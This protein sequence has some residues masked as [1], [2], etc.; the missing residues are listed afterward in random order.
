MITYVNGVSTSASETNTPN[1]SA[2]GLD[3][4]A[5]TYNNNNNWFRGSIDEARISAI[6]RSADW[7]KTEYTN[8]NSPSTFTAVG[9][10]VIAHTHAKGLFE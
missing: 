6:A 5:S 4:G 8:Q 3:L 2:G 7:I 10:Q 1:T 9:S